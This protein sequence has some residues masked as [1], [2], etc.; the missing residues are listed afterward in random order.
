[1][2]HRIFL[3]TLMILYLGFMIGWI[4]KADY[5]EKMFIVEKHKQ[6]SN[7]SW[8]EAWEK[9]KNTEIRAHLV[10]EGLWCN[11]DQ[12][13]VELVF[14]D[15]DKEDIIGY[16]IVVHPKP[17]SIWMQDIGWKITTWEKPSMNADLIVRSSRNGEK[18]TTDC[19]Y[20]RFYFKY[21]PRPKT[22]KELNEEPIK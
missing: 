15:G 12:K 1:M 13:L 21:K 11:D 9:S 20:T 17:G 22:D 18:D 6:E 7:G 19:G 2:K 3:W 4:A 8:A 10:I 5:S 14:K 16:A